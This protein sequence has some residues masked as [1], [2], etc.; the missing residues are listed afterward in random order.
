MWVGG[1]ERGGEITFFFF[2][3]FWYRG[4]W[5]NSRR[6]S[7]PNTPRQEEHDTRLSG[8]RLSAGNANTEWASKV[9]TVLNIHRNRTAY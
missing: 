1:E 7:L 5:A 3:F 4:N 9:N 6:G 8:C 2:F